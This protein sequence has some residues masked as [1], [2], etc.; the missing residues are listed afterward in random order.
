DLLEL[1]APGSRTCRFLRK[2]VPYAIG[3]T[4]NLYGIEGFHLEDVLGIV[5]LSQPQALTSR[6]AAVD[7]DTR[8]EVPR[9]MSVID[10]R[11]ETRSEPNVD[12]ATKVDVAAVRKYMDQMLSLSSHLT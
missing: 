10:S 3:A 11:T 7:V 4:S 9:G 1:P 8:G 12:M 5:A 6:P 2:I